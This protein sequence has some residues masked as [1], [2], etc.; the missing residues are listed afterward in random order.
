MR[1]A[2]D[3][4]LLLLAL[5]FGAGLL[6]PHHPPT[7]VARGFLP[8]LAV[9]P[10]VAVRGGILPLA[11]LAALYLGA[12]ALVGPAADAAWSGAEAGPC[13]RHLREAELP[14]PG[15]TTSHLELE[16]RV[17]G[18]PAIGSE[19]ARV[20]LEVEK[21]RI[22]GQD[23]RATRGLR[24]ELGLPSAL[25]PLP[26][27]RLRAFAK[28]DDPPPSTP[29]ARRD[30]AERRRQGVACVGRVE[31][32]RVGV[33][34]E[35]TGWWAAIERARRDLA[36]RARAALAAP[37][38]AAL[39]PA[40]MVGDRSGVQP[41]LRDAFAD[42]GLAHV[43]SVSGLHLSLCVLGLY[44]ILLA[45]FRWTLG[46]WIDIHRWAALA[47]LPFAPLYAAFTGAQPP[48]LRAAVGAALFLLAQALARQSD[49]WTSLAVAF[50]GVVAFDPPSLF[51]ASFQLS[52]AACAGLLGLGPSL[53]KLIPRPPRG[54]TSAR[55]LGHLLGALEATLA[56]TLATLPLLAL[57][58]QRVSLT[59]LPA[60]VV[61]VP[62]ALAATAL[63]ALAGA[64]GLIAPI[65]FEPLLFLAGK[66]TELLAALARFFAALPGARLFLP[67]PSLGVGAAFLG[68]LLALA[69]YAR[70]PRAALAMALASSLALGAAW[71][72]P[73]PD[74]VLRIDF[75]PVGQGDATLL[76][77][78][79]GEAVLVDT[80]GGL[81]DA[82]DRADLDLLPL[83]AERGVGRL[84]ALV[85]S[86]LHPDHVGSAPGLLSR[87]PVDEVWFTG[88]AL[89]GRL[90][91][92][93][94]EAIATRG[95]P[96]R[97][98]AAG[99][100]AI[101]VGGVVFEFLGPPD[102]GGAKDEPL[103]GDNDASLVLRVRHDAIAVLLPGDVEAEG[104]RA[105]LESGADLRAH[106]LKA[107]HH[108]SRTSSSEAFLDAVRPDHAIF[109]VG[110]RN[111]F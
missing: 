109:C 33:V 16:G 4:P 5:A 68:L 65:A 73:R 67:L 49:G 69:L 21:A 86:H 47:A 106:L 27:D 102:V 20:R 103:F 28:L 58:F 24:V 88:R 80:G 76:R 37:D 35:A 39:V 34:D 104:E 54:T 2:V 57:H 110:W 38:A 6:L 13:A 81:R 15:T 97:R 29:R 43:L 30:L 22:P 12:G 11:V 94:A 87:I 100:P 84:R 9:V 75:L 45:L 99:S 55:I 93:I 42:S 92:P 83:L 63:A 32:D 105:L 66:A 46:A 17:R 23:W 26:G 59:S 72:A 3:R 74:P 98:F 64:A 82:P 95:I 1:P 52:F 77:L 40:L 44:R 60:N 96:L 70:R 111:A 14:P 8:L 41:K 25:A 78:P 50:L 62:I 48:V 18:N 101:E 79:S 91:A 108:G 19:W 7:A 90:G 36:R 61:A 31:A 10:L 71:L 85:I 89:E 53:R 51:T 56:A 107:P